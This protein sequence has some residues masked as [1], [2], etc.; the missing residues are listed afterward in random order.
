MTVEEFKTILARG[1]L[2]RSLYHFTDTANLPSIAEHGVLSKLRL[3]AKGIAV[4]VPG[5]NE[6]SR[7]ADA[8]KGLE[9][10]VNLCFT[11]SHP[12]CHVAHV[13][14]RMPNPQYLPVD[15]DILKVEGVKITLDV[16]NKAGTELYDVEDGL[17]NLDMRVL[18][19]RT[20]WDDAQI[21]ERLQK[22]EKCEILVPDIVPIDLIR[23]KF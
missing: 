6:W 9:G 8:L 17:D 11:K 2:Y 22:A 14:G 23:R 7:N 10:Y 13:S 18:Y 16:A 19:T 1:H 3:S 21:Q 20:N 12:M 4:A 5:G 15:P